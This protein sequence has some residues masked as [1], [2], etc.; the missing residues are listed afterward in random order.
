MVAFGSAIIFSL[1]IRDGMLAINC[2]C[3]FVKKAR[4][5]RVRLDGG[6]LIAVPI[7]ST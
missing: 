4:V 6:R 7:S 3:D 1:L 2:C 5:V